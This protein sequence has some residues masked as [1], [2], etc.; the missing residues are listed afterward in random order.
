MGGA[1]TLTLTRDK[2]PITDSNTTFTAT[3]STTS[4]AV[5]RALISAFN[6]ALIAERDPTLGYVSATTHGSKVVMIQGGGGGDGGGEDTIGSR[7]VEHRTHMTHILP[8]LLIS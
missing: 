8:V 3:I 6:T 5:L 7:I 1:G 2:I 4:L